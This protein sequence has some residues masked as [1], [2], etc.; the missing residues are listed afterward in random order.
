MSLAAY[1]FSRSMLRQQRRRRSGSVLS[2]GGT[3]LVMH[4]PDHRRSDSVAE[5]ARDD[6]EVHLPRASSSERVLDAGAVG[7]PSRPA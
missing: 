1:S 6:V 3:R 2:R 7:M 4:R 5:S